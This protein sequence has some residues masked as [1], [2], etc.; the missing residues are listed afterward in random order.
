MHC[1]HPQGEVWFFWKVGLFWA[2][3]ISEN[4]IS[5]E[6]TSPALNEYLRLVVTSGVSVGVM[7]RQKVT[8]SLI[9]K[10]LLQPAKKG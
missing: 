4:I 5:H 8:P 10:L 7:S 9:G 3:T 2:H 6:F 1:C